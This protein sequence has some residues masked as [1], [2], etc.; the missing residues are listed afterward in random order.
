M[1]FNFPLKL[2]GAGMQMEGKGICA[3]LS[4]PIN[5]VFINF[6]FLFEIIFLFF[7]VF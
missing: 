7:W 5:N 4:L 1:H 2:K 3:L 6:Y